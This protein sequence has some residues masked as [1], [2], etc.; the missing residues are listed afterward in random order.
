MIGRLPVGSEE[1]EETIDSESDDEPAEGEEEGPSEP[2]EESRGRKY[3]QRFPDREYVLLTDEGE[4]E[5]FEEAKRDT[6]NRE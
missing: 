2:T 1:E 3:P 5:S 4:P 6:H